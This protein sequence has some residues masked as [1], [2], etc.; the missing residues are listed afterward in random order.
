[1]KE[2]DRVERGS[3]SPGLGPGPGLPHQVERDGAYQSGWW[4][5]D[6][7]LGTSYWSKYN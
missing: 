3:V 2:G 5:V 6:R 4:N 7:S 1:M